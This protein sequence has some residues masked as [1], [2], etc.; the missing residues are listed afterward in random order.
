MQY[1]DKIKSLGLEVLENEPLREHSTFRIG[2][3][4]RHF[5]SVDSNDMIE[6]VVKLATKAKAEFLVI[7]GGSNILFNDK[8]YDGL[9]IKAAGGR[10]K[11]KRDTIECDA[12]VPLA[13][14]MGEAIGSG[15]AGLEWAA[16]IPGTVGG[17]VRGNAGAYGRDMSGNVIQV[18]VFRNGRT[19]NLKAKHCNFGYRTSMFQEA[20]NTDIILSVTL[21]LERSDREQLKEKVQEIVRERAPKFAGFSAGC[22][23]RN[24]EIGAEAAR[25]FKAKHQ[26]FPEQFVTY[27]KIPSGW[28]IDQ[29]GF[30]GRQVGGAKVSEKHAAVIINEGSATAE[31]VMMLI[32]LIK[33]KV[34][35]EFGIQLHEEIELVGF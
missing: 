35:D 28:L 18:K 32:S 1:L 26:E 11:I 29:C 5:V 6:K 13:K 3:P 15:L 4:A 21:K 27:G 7:G 33:Q 8:G 14:A 16:G 24:V 20:G 9:V 17:A 25:Q 22:V 2:G 31:N 23:F 10:L 34:R 19:R 30:K 12:G